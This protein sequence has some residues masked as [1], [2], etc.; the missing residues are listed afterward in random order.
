MTNME[1]K[2]FSI[3]ILLILIGSNFPFNNFKLIIADTVMEAPYNPSLT[4]DKDKNLVLIYKEK[5]GGYSKLALLKTIFPYKWNLTKRIIVE[6]ESDTE[7]NSN[8]KI[9]SSSENLFIVYTTRNSS[10]SQ[11]TILKDNPTLDSWEVFFQLTNNSCVYN[12]PSISI[13]NV[14]LWLT[15]TQDTSNENNFYCNHYNFTS[16][17]WSQ[18][19]LISEANGYNSLYCDFFVDNNFEGHFVWSEGEINYRKVYYRHLYTNNTLTPIEQ[20]TDGSTNCIFSKV[21]VDGFNRTLVFWSN[22]TDPSAT[23]LGTINIHYSKRSNST[24]PWSEPIFFAPYLPPDREGMMADSKKPYIALSP[25]KILYVSYEDH[26]PYPYYMG[27]ALRGLYNNT[28][29]NG[30]P[31]SLTVAPC[32]D[33]VIVCDEQNYVHCVWVD[34]RISYYELYYRIKYTNETWSF[35]KQ[36][37]FYS[38]TAYTSNAAKYFGIILGGLVI[39]AIIPTTIYY[40]LKKRKR[41][42]ILLQRKKEIE[43]S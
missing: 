40:Y 24:S 33:P 26:Q 22:Y 3:L 37:T 16:E 14:T 30:E 21:F 43:S 36:L 9:V 13:V 8:P 35:E 2:F 17:L 23:V 29:F 15:W 5:I 1:Q 28:L 4:L 32:F 11:L 31:I 18:N 6:P 25:N 34:Y 41:K 10:S 42:Q 20:I 39:F 38:S 7:I 19:L 12:N 27:I